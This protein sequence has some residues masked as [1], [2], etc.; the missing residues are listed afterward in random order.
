MG[1]PKTLDE[2]FEA[3]EITRR[4][5][6]SLCT[7]LEELAAQLSEEEKDSLMRCNLIMIR[8]CLEEF[9]THW[10]AESRLNY[11]LAQAMKALNESISFYADFSTWNLH[12]NDPY[13][14]KSRA[15]LDSGRRAREVFIF[16]KKILDGEK[17]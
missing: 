5:R 7:N 15:D 9:G 3:H 1:G 16:V 17:L 13:S 2:F 4:L 8:Q 14:E 6:K 12:L 11:Q 10:E